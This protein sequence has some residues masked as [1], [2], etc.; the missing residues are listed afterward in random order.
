VN[1]RLLSSDVRIARDRLSQLGRWYAARPRGTDADELEALVLADR[2]LERT[3][4]TAR[5]D[6]V[7]EVDRRAGPFAPPLLSA[8]LEVPRERFVRAADIGESAMDTPL[9]LDDEGL[10][11]ISAPHAYLLSFRVLDL[12]PGDRLA[13]LGAGSGYGAAL[14][15]QVVSPSGSVLTVE[16]D[17][18]LAARAKRLLFAHSNIEVLAGD[19]GE[20]L[21]SWSGFPRIVVT[22]AVDEIPGAWLDA[23]PEQ[24]RM[25]AP[26]GRE[27]AQRLLAVDRVGGKL[28]W[29]DHGAVR[30]V[31]N[32]GPTSHVE[33]RRS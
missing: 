33:E 7:V 4:R 14:A 23:I 5:I 16:I 1:D 20:R 2:D 24:G 25:V 18:L 26:V 6:L 11:T 12:R 3:G 9:L 22:F 27:N 29:S 8:L 17:D 15:S 30:Y 28:V 21:T 31:R 13:E 10:A 32:R 19:A